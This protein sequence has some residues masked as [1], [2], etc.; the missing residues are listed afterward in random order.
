MGRDDANSSRPR[1][2]E[3]QVLK[4]L[5][6]RRSQ[7]GLAA[8]CC[9]AATLAGRVLELS[10]NCTRVNLPI[11]DGPGAIVSLGNPVTDQGCFVLAELVSMG[12]FVKVRTLN[13]QNQTGYGLDAQLVSTVP[14]PKEPAFKGF[15]VAG[16]SALMEAARV[17]IGGLN[18]LVNADFSQ[19]K[20][21]DDGMDH[22]AA[23]LAAGAFPSLAMLKLYRNKFGNVGIQALARGL[24]AKEKVPALRNVYVGLT[25]Q[26]LAEISDET[27]AAIQAAGCKGTIKHGVR[28]NNE[29][30]A[31]HLA[32][33]GPGFD[34]TMEQSG[35]G[36]MG[37]GMGGGALDQHLLKTTGQ[38]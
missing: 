33:I 30:C 15:T 18:A 16:F 21:G 37:Q 5:E 20:I 22:L 3:E 32:A 24:A 36:L 4:F 7:F 38:T 34:Y 26:K 8:A 28:A 27:K 17:D 31:V 23:A 29:G 9:G 2:S 11:G 19:N 1:P 6:S 10:S 13:L 14:V 25:P 12:A 35:M